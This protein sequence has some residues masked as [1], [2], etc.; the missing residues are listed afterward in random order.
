MRGRTDER[1]HERLR[2]V[3]FFI[4][5]YLVPNYEMMNRFE[6]W[7]TPLRRRPNSNHLIILGEHASMSIQ[8]HFEFRETI[9]FV[10]T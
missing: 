9:R 3:L 7:S 10:S 6:T 5:N 8:T 1:A 2:S 4:S